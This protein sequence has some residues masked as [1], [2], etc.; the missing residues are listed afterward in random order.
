MHNIKKNFTY[1]FLFRILTVI[2]PLITSPI[3]ARALGAKNVGIFSANLAYVSYFMFLAKLGVDNYGNRTIAAIQSDRAKRQRTFWNIYAVQLISSCLAL[4]LYGISII[5][6][7][8]DRRIILLLQNLWI[9]S[10]LLDINWFYFGMEEFRLTVMRN[11]IVKIVEVIS[12][13]LFINEPSDLYLYVVIMAGSAFASQ[14]IMWFHLRNYISFEMPRK[15]RM[16]PHVKPML[17]LFIPVIAASIFHIMDKSMLDVLSSDENVG[18]YYSAEKIIN[19]PLGLITAISTVMLPRISNVIHNDSISKVKE[20]IGKS[21]ELTMFIMCAVSFGIAG[22][23]HE[24]VPLFFGKGYEPCEF[25]IYLFV[26]VMLTRAF[27]E[28][29]RAQYLMPAKKDRQ[30][31]LAICMGALINILCNYIFILLFG[32]WG[33]VIGTLAAELT[34]LVIELYFS[35]EIPFVKNALVQV[36]YLIYGA[37]MFV[38]LRYISSLISGSALFKV[39]LLILIGAMIYMLLSL[40][41]WLKDEQSIFH[42]Y[43]KEYAGR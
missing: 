39:L 10:C 30:Y 22:I 14:F 9:I 23:A 12:I 2:T 4:V 36:R 31:T 32:V 6:M 19:I 3:I 43:L 15:K 7:A 37:V 41:T 17:I 28:T 27:N 29:I 33:A 35:K 21:M 26:P 18:Y 1:Q 8:P 38:L 42:S 24:F 16:V 11:V 25:L 5:F 20:L 34:V 13:V 40:I